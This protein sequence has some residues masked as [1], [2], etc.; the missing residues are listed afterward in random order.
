[1]KIKLSADLFE[2]YLNDDLNNIVLQDYDVF[3]KRTEAQVQLMDNTGIVLMDSIG[4]SD[5]GK[6]L[7]SEDIISAQNGN[8]GKYIYKRNFNNINVMSLSAP[9]KSRGQQIG[10]IRLRV[11][12]R[13]SVV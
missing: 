11:A 5:L 1:M 3:Y 9:L 4:S 6:K 2:A 8:M 12:D 13:K 7:E 10:I